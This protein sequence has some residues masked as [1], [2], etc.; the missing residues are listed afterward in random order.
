VI[1]WEQMGGYVIVLCKVVLAVA[2]VLSWLPAGLSSPEVKC[3]TE[4]PHKLGLICIALLEVLQILCSNKR[5]HY[6]KRGKLIL[7]TNWDVASIMYKLSGYSQCYYQM[8]NESFWQLHKLLKDKIST[9]YKRK[10]GK[11]PNGPI[12][13]EIWLSCALCYFSGG[14]PMDIA[15]VHGISWSQVFDQSGW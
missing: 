12:S 8:S 9:S 13:T 2:L 14:D 3:A 11:M 10:H 7:C 1:P 15:L 4:V 5:H 6:C